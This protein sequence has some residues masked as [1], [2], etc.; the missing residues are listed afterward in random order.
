MLRNINNPRGFRGKN[1]R[2][3]F[4]FEMKRSGGTLFSYFKPTSNG[5]GSGK[6]IK[7]QPATPLACKTGSKPRTKVC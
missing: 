1:K 7:K 5:V 6:K 2:E 4:I 3:L